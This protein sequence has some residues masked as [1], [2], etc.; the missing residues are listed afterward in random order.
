[1]MQEE[2][3]SRSRDGSEEGGKAHIPRGHPGGVISEDDQAKGDE[4]ESHHLVCS[5]ALQKRR[6][7]IEEKILHLEGGGVAAARSRPFVFS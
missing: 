1:M 4:A 5:V 3:A 6:I 7:P 2:L